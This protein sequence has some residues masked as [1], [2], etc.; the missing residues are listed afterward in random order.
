MAYAPPGRFLYAWYWPS[1]YSLAWIAARFVDHYFIPG[2]VGD[3]VE[4]IC[5]QLG[6]PPSRITRFNSMINIERHALLNAASR[7]SIREKKVWTLMLSS[8]PWL[9]GLYLRKA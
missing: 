6:V 1:L 2:V 5:Q 9:V 7:A 8:L 3:G 4:D